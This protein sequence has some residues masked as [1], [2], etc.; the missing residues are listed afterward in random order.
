MT[1][2]VPQPSVVDRG[3]FTRLCVMMLLQYMTYGSW[4][5]T[6][7][8]V[9]SSH[10]LGNI[11]GLAFSLAAIAAMISPMVIG[12]IADRFFQSQKILAL[13]HA[14]GGL[15][16][17]TLAPIVE[18]GN[19]GL[20]LVV[21]FVYMLFFQPTTGMTNSIAFAHLPAKSNAFAYI[22]AFG[23]FG[24]IVMGLVIGQSGLSAST[25]IFWIATG[26]SF[27]LAV[28]SLTL[29]KTP[30]P[31]R[32][33]RFSIGDVV[34][35]GA[36]H[37][38]RNRS[39][40]V[41]VV[42]VLLVSVPISIYNSYG[43]TYL[44]TAGVPNVAS[45]MT[46]GQAAELVCL[47]IVPVFLR[48]FSIKWVLLAGLVAWVVRAAGLLVMTG[49]NLPLAIFVIAL[50]GVCNDF[51]VMTA[52]MYVDHI[53]RPQAR[54]QAQSLFVFISLG[55]GNAIGAYLAGVMYNAFVAGSPDSVS[56]WN[57]LWYVTG[58]VT[59]LS[60]IIMAIGFRRPE[61]EPEA[62]VADAANSLVD[63][64]AAPESATAGR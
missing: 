23:T 38:F 49:G 57:P 52:M 13:M 16:L 15:L 2:T 44:D 62:T 54:A 32:G 42:C 33:S 10:G 60:A 37:L 45:I 11:V 61:R 59:A 53:T 5:A 25:S 24:W 18:A 64:A 56:A 3:A 7:G 40:V 12:A 19:A 35:A 1:S 17:L 48:R 50:H 39:F 55:L 28:Y 14:L 36:F 29:P 9:L 27:L 31:A 58:G 26:M 8:L 43:S 63:G 47:V 4:W 34:G 22:R 41:L 20:L 6:I 30:P 46:I 51:F 21:L